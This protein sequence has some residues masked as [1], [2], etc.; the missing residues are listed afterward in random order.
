MTQLLTSA[1]RLERARGFRRYAWKL[2]GYYLLIAVV[3][4]PAELVRWIGDK[5][6]DFLSWLDLPAYRMRSAQEELRRELIRDNRR[7][8]RAEN[9]DVELP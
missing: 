1:E 3:A 9:P 5:A 7:R 4:V 8:A 2:L 6:E